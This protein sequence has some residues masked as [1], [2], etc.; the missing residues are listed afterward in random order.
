MLLRGVEEEAAL[1]ALSQMVCPE[2]EAEE[3]QVQI[4]MVG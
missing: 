3:V 1:L 2:G 4:L